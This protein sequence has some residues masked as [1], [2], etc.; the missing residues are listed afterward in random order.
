MYIKYFFM[1][2]FSF[3]SHLIIHSDTGSTFKNNG[4]S[5]H[6]RSTQVLVRS[7][8]T[9][10]ALGGHLRH[11]ATQKLE[12]SSTWAL[13]VLRHSSS[14]VLKALRHS[15]TWALEALYL[16][17]SNSGRSLFINHINPIGSWGPK[18]NNK[19]ITSIKSSLSFY[20]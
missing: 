8:G 16:A 14:R 18:P 2:S 1:L 17:D 10:R 9:Q 11:S 7:E 4:T 13:R 3:Q 12:H 5:R 20:Y 6:S 19:I 15:G